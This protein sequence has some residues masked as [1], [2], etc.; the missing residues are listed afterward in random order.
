M[1]SVW[2]IFKKEKEKDLQNSNIRKNDKVCGDKM[3]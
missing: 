2:L 3:K 1:P